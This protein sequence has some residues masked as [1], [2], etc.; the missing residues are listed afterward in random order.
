MDNKAFLYSG[1]AAFIASGLVSVVTYNQNLKLHEQIKDGEKLRTEKI[2][3]KLKPSDLHINQ[4][5]R[6]NCARFLPRDKN[7]KII[8][9][10]VTDANREEIQN[11][12]SRFTRCILDCKFDDLVKI[13]PFQRIQ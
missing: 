1:V 2:V 13:P 11:M 9:I 12:N 3:N 10:P 6:N 5:C 8:R 7:G 4:I